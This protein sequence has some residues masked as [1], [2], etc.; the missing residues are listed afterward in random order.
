MY[1]E[2]GAKWF[3]LAENISK[4]NLS[5]FLFNMGTVWEKMNAAEN[6]I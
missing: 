4:N 3:K 1:L 6:I 2:T 5:S